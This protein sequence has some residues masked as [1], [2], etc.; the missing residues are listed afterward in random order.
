MSSKDRAIGMS[1][2]HGPALRCSLLV[3][4]PIA[5]ETWL[6]H[7]LSRWSVWGRSWPAFMSRGL[8]ASSNDRATTMSCRHGP[9]LH[10]SLLVIS[11]IA[12]ETQLSHGLSHRSLW[13]RSWS[14]SISRG[15]LASSKH[16]TTSMGRRRGPALRHP[17]LAIS[18]FAPRTP[19][20][21]GLSRRSLWRRSWPA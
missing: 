17:Q 15:L 7:D 14:T 16:R 19:M 21:H 20:S 13:G 18:S 5:P 12:P 1:R 8:L 6:L 9:A 4:S 11:P 10:C 2:R 3:I